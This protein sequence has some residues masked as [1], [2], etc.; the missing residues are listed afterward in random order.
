MSQE[1]KALDD[2]QARAERAEIAGLLE[3]GFLHV[4]SISDGEPWRRLRDACD[5]RDRLESEGRKARVLHR[6]AVTRVYATRPK[7]REPA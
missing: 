3:A 2:V 1:E 6:L 4:R 5:L 7:R